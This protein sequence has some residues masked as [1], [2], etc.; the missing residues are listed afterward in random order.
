MSFQLVDVKPF[1]NKVLQKYN[2]RPQVTQILNTYLIDAEERE[3]IKIKGKLIMTNYRSGKENKPFTG[4][5]LIGSETLGNEEYLNAVYQGKNPNKDP[6]AFS[7]F[8]PGLFFAKDGVLEGW[9]IHFNLKT[10]IKNNICPVDYVTYTKKGKTI[11]VEKYNENETLKETYMKSESENGTYETTYMYTHQ[12]KKYA[13]GTPYVAKAKCVKDGKVVYSLSTRMQSIGNV[14]FLLEG[15]ERINAP[16]KTSYYS[17]SDISIPRFKEKWEAYTMTINNHQYQKIDTWNY[18]EKTGVLYS[19]VEELVISKERR[20]LSLTYYNG[21]GSM[22]SKASHNKMVR[23][24][25]EGFMSVREMDRGQIFYPSGKLFQTYD[26]NEKIVYDENGNILCTQKPYKGNASD[27]RTK[28]TEGNIKFIERDDVD[29]KWKIKLFYKENLL[30]ETVFDKNR[31]KE[32]KPLC[33]IYYYDNGKPA[34]ESYGAFFNYPW[35]EKREDD[36]NVIKTFDENGVEVNRHDEKGQVAIKQMVKI[37][38]MIAKM[39]E[40]LNNWGIYEAVINTVP[41]GKGHKDDYI[42]TSKL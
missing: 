26:G 40:R 1:H 17:Y 25:E 24:S 35:S 39:W 42:D 6:D 29:E 33:G 34:T 9:C 22:Q 10:D 5:F 28:Y 37:E 12:S 38:V 13:K 23:C 21:N 15:A 19:F 8:G 3:N 18:R 31:T 32:Y 11:L 20:K 30:Y 4:Y 41:L 7:I 16:E 36:V 14:E 2:P 27:I